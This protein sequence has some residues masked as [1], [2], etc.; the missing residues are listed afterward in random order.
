MAGTERR[1]KPRVSLDTEAFI[2]IGGKKIKGRTHNLAAQGVAVLCQLE[3]AVGDKVKV[4]ILL[5][6]EAGWVVVE[7]VLVRQE[8]RGEEAVWGLKFERPDNWT[9]SHIERYIREQL[10]TQA[11]QKITGQAAKASARRQREK[12]G[13]PLVRL[14]RAAITELTGKKPR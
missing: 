14:F 12:G 7:A 10:A 11:R 6:N 13:N 2:E 5:P 9:V 3:Q 1:K 4:H 8:R